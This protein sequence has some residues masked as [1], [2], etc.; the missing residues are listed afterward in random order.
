VR[1]CP[2]VG[3][4]RTARARQGHRTRNV[5]GLIWPARQAEPVFVTVFLTEGPEQSRARDAVLA[6]VGAA[7]YATLGASPS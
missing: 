3:S 6:E 1:A 7:L 4:S 5:V 2:R